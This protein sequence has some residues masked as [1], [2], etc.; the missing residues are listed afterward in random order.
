MSGRKEEAYFKEAER[1]Y[2]K[3]NKTPEQIAEILPVCANTAYKWS[4]KGGW[5]KK[6]EAAQAAL[7][8]PRN[9]AERMWAAV[10]KYLAII[11]G[12]AEDG[13]LDNATF[14]ALNKAV[15]AIRGVERQSVDKRV[16]S[17]E[18]MQDFTDFLKNKDLPAGELQ[19]IGGRVREYFRSLE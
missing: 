8:S 17:I 15:A 11:E 9:I 6:R 16:M 1:L 13:V 4:K 5:G 3:E 2:V 10:E 18:V 14:D 7:A 12:R 19:L